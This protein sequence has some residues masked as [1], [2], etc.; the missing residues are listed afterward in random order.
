MC[1][2]V[3]TTLSGWIAYARELRFQKPNPSPLSWYTTTC[4]TQGVYPHRSD[5][6][7]WLD[8]SHP[9]RSTAPSSILFSETTEPDHG[10]FHCVGVPRYFP[11]P[12]WFARPCQDS[13]RNGSP[14]LY[15]FAGRWKGCIRHSTPSPHIEHFT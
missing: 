10:I 3:P 11:S 14:C 15:T 4:A 2:P 5:R 12:F 13:T 7:R 1:P 9:D 6:L 8:F